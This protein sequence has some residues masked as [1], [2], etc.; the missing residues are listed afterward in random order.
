MKVCIAGD[1][2]ITRDYSIDC[3]VS[4]QVLSLF[5]SADYGILNLECPITESCD[6]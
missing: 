4:E 5:S 6:T 1:F 3:S 2:C